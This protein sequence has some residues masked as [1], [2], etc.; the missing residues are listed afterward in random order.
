M[1]FEATVPQ[2]GWSGEISK[3]Y[4][5]SKDTKIDAEKI[6]AS[7]VGQKIFIMT[8]SVV[9]LAGGLT[10]VLLNYALDPLVTIL[11]AVVLALSSLTLG[12]VYYI[13]VK[14]SATKTLLKWAIRVMSVFRKSWDPQNFRSKAEA[15]LGRFHGDIAQLKANPHQLIIPIISSIIAFIFEISVIAF[16]FLALGQTVPVAV[17]LIVFTLTGTL[18]S[19]GLTF[20]FPEIIMTTA[21]SALGITPA[22]LGFAVALLARVV[23]LWFRLVVS[24]AALQYAGLG[25]LRKR[26]AQSVDSP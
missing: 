8:I 21:F 11:I 7:V 5:L 25:F 19:V 2:L 15:W 13:S 6:G 23:N 18:Q 20:L 16:A 24:Y 22:S 12:L 10:L 14:P 1:F 4:L 3:T 17:V 9:A 26:S